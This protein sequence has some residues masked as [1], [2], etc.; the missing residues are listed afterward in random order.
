VA[1]EKLKRPLRNE[2]LTSAPQLKCM[3]LGPTE[4]IV[5]ALTVG[6]TQ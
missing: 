5:D 4:R 6:Y 2:S 3:P 1:P